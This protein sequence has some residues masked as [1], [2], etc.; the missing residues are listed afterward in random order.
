MHVLHNRHLDIHQAHVER[1]VSIVG[2]AVLADEVEGL[3]TIIRDRDFMT[4]DLE[5]TSQD[6]RV[7]EVVLSRSKG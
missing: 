7:D 4:G 2:D 1:P 5:L 3:L 6:A